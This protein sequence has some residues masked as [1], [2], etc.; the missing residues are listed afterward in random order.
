M[1]SSGSIPSAQHKSTQR[2]GRF[3]AD[4]HA[5]QL[6]KKQREKLA[7]LP[8]SSDVLVEKTNIKGAVAVSYLSGSRSTVVTVIAANGD[9][10]EF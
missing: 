8:G 10:A 6:T 2:N 3:V 1:N 7:E 9:T 4:P 5:I